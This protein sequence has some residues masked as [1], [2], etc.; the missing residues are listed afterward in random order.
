MWPLAELTENNDITPDAPTT[1]KFVEFFLGQCSSLKEVYEQEMA[2]ERLTKL[3]DILKVPSVTDRLQNSYVFYMEYVYYITNDA[4]LASQ[5]V[6]VVD[7]I[8]NK[9]PESL[10]TNMPSHEGWN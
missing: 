9:C 6:G 10:S 7:H 2:Q 8:N 5:D 4:S 1:E 3:M